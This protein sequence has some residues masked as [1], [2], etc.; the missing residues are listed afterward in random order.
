MM[1][2]LELRVVGELVKK[3]EFEEELERRV[4]VGR[5]RAS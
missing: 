5:K 3:A 2:A 1:E 4:G